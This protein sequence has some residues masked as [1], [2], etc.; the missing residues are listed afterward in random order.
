MHFFIKL[1]PPR[2]SFH[3]DMSDEERSGMQKHIEY[4]QELLKNGTAIIYGPVF[5]PNRSFGMG[6][7]DVENEIEA[8]LICKND[9]TIISGLN[10]NEFYPMK[11]I[12]RI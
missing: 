7:I 12:F 9:P 1:I 5:E 8:S 10:N 11:A 2:A 3:L 6:I 4:W